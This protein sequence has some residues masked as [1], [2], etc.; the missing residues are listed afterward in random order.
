MPP[1]T[2]VP[3]VKVLMAWLDQKDPLTFEFLTKHYY[4]LFAYHAAQRLTTFNFFIVS[5]SFLSN[6]FALLVTKGSV[7]FDIMGSVLAFTAYI[8]ILA[9]GRLDKRNEQIILINE[10][11]LKMVQKVI[12][13]RIQ[14]DAWKT[15]ER[16]DHEARLWRTFGQLL[17]LIYVVAA[18]LA[19]VGGMD[20]LVMGHQTSLMFA[21]LGSATLIVLAFLAINRA[22][23]LRA[24]NL[25]DWLIGL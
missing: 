24:E 7:Q 23:P 20:A 1:D 8:L 3:D 14:S 13:Q 9:F 17:P 4:D 6:A 10:Q 5:L 18:S 21:V 25:M 2:G 12:A 15:F 19:V 11:P 16:A 22:G